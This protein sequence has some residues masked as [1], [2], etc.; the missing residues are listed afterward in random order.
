MPKA[1]NRAF[2]FDMMGHF[3][4]LETLRVVSFKPTKSLDLI[5]DAA[6]YVDKEIVEKELPSNE[7]RR[8]LSLQQLTKA[9]QT[10]EDMNVISIDMTRVNA[11]INDPEVLTH[12][13]LLQEYPVL[14]SLS[15]NQKSMVSLAHA[16]S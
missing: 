11:L 2:L 16:L 12:Y 6:L 4:N 9:L 15:N 3:K 8:E 13:R 10:Y 1:R 5:E 14:L 7:G